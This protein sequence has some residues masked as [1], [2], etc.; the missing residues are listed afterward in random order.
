MTCS[1]QSAYTQLNAASPIVRPLGVLVLQ[2]HLIFDGA[3][4]SSGVYSVL[5]K[6]S[7]HLCAHSG[8][9]LHRDVLVSSLEVSELAAEHEATNGR[10]AASIL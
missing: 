7:T 4:H 2:R 3:V 9:I 8:T 5:T 10:T 6:F 1:V